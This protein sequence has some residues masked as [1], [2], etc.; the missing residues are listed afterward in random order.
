MSFTLFSTELIFRERGKRT[1]SKY[2]LSFT[3]FVVSEKYNNFCVLPYP[4][5]PLVSHHLTYEKTK[6]ESIILSAQINYTS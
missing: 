1:S 6:V 3:S 2:D 4:Q 5:V